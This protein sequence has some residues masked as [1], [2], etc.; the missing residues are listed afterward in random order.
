M[1]VVRGRCLFPAWRAIFMGVNIA[2]I[3]VFLW[4]GAFTL[5]VHC[6]GPPP[7]TSHC[8]LQTT[9]KKKKPYWEKCHI[10]CILL[11]MGWFQST[12][13]QSGF[14]E[15]EKGVVTSLV[16]LH[17]LLNEKGQG[18]LQ[19]LLSTVK[20]QHYTNNKWEIYS[21]VQFLSLFRRIFFLIDKLFLLIGWII[22][23][24][25]TSFSTQESIK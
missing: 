16:C 14:A 4:S 24:T 8:I 3:N 23:T 12:L 10:C 17:L 6:S 25:A 1:A 2:E 13:A 5:K 15:I 20:Y 9:T 19:S 7:G 11:K 21:P 22:H 18:G